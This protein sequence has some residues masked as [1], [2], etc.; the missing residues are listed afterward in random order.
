MGR[1]WT[2]LTIASVIVLM[3]VVPRVS[4]VRSVSGVVRDEAGLPLPGATVRIKTTEVATVTDKDG[5]FT[6]T[7]FAPSFRVRATA[8]HEGHY[9]GGAG[10]LPWKTNVSITLDPH[11]VADDPEYTWVPPAVRA[12]SALGEWVTGASLGLAAMISF[13][14][15]FLPLA[16]RLSLGCRDCHRGGLYEEWDS[17]GHALGVRN[18]RFMSMYN[19]TDLSGN[20]SPPTRSGYDRDYGSFPLPPDPTRPYFGPGYKLDFPATAG[21]C[22]ACHL[23]TAAIER[24]YGADPNHVVGVDALGVHCDFCHKIGAVRLDAESG[25]PFENMPGIL[26]VELMRPRSDRQL[27]FGPYD[28]VDVGPDTYLPLTRQSEICAPCHD[29][30]FWGVPI[31]ESFA[32]WRAS[33]YP[34]EGKPCQSCH[35]KPDGISSN[36]APG[37]GGQK[38]D[39]D[40]IPTHSFPG[41]AAEALLRESVNLVTEATLSAHLLRVRV[42]IHNDRVGHDVPT[43]SPLRHLILVVRATGA[44]GRALAQ[45]RGPRLPEWCGVGEPAKGR[46]AGLPG[47]AY[48]KVLEE[49]WTRVSP[50]GAYW[51][52]TR[53]VSDN[54]I[55]ARASDATRYTFEAPESGEALVEVTLIFRRAFIDL[56]EQ[57]GWSAPDIVMAQESLVVLHGSPDE[58]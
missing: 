3:A 50:T 4:K 42:K 9:I 30:S 39:P 33:P 48:A 36:F 43:D 1:R 58:G 19:G 52:R 29:A 54:R 14:R 13:D 8:W 55:P 10:A 44:D 53:L 25:R 49:L 40:S 41:A 51:N 45:V 34:A 20:R 24:P 12:R 7:G 38:R 35:M 37:R 17:S 32:E 15:A 16:D 28:D 47:K 27:F 31:Y 22:G 11:P 21:N 23:P 18:P 6:L 46:Y 56:M 2:L 5:G 26:S 57:K